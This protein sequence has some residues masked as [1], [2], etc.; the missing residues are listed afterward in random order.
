MT[1][2]LEGGGQELAS[3]SVAF[4]D[5]VLLPLPTEGAV[6]MTATPER[7]FDLGAGK[8]RPLQAEIRGGVVGLIVD[9]RGRRPFTLP[10]DRDER[11]ARLRIWN[12]A[13][14]AYPREV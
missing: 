13:L 14:N 2:L 1:V 11:I 12:Q 8:G 6:R 10:S 9:A 7:G 3:R 4:G 5:L